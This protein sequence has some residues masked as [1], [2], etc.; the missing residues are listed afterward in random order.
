MLPI[1]MQHGVVQGIDPFEIFRVEGVLGADPM[2]GLGTQIGLQKP[3]DRTQDGKTRQAEL[4]AVIF[5]AL[6][7]VLLQEGVEH[8]AGCLLDLRQGAIEL[9]LGADQRIDMLDRRHLDVLGGRR[10]G[11]RRQGLT[12]RIGHEVQME[13]A[14]GAMGHVLRRDNL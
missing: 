14:A 4:A 11:D 10:P 8:D 3:Q 6:D 9:L 2:G 1:V 13:K 5:E 7:Q 12:G